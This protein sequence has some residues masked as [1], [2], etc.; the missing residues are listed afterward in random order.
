MSYPYLPHLCSLYNRRQESNPTTSLK[1]PV[2]CATGSKQETGFCVLTQ[3]E[4]RGCSCLPSKKIMSQLCSHAPHNK[5]AL[6]TE[7]RGQKSVLPG[8]GRHTSSL[9]FECGKNQFITGHAGLN[10][11]RIEH[12]LCT[13]REGYGRNDSNHKLHQRSVSTGGDTGG[14]GYRR[15]YSKPKLYQ[16]SLF[17]M[18]IS[19][20][21]RTREMAQGVEGLLCRPDYLSSV[22]RTQKLIGENRQTRILL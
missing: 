9:L 2:S 17:M 4:K 14:E 21:N 6:M 15:E 7:G 10:S 18:F 16:S 3:L 5:R 1:N 12:S 11:G 13:G 19:R 20:I 22:P 8:K